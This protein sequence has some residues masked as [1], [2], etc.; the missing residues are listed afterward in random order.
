MSRPLEQSF[1]KKAATPPPNPL[2]ASV[3]KKPGLPKPA[4]PTSTNEH[5]LIGPQTLLED[6]TGSYAFGDDTPE[7]SSVVKLVKFFSAPTKLEKVHFPL[8]TFLL[9]K[10]KL[11]LEGEG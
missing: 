10:V 2:T 9:E 3:K 1:R 7:F 8:W 5:E 4:P 6:V 11:K